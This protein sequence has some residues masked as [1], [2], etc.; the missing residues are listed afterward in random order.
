MDQDS[1]ISVWE[2]Y[3]AKTCPGKESEKSN[4]QKHTAKYSYAPNIGPAT[5][6]SAY[7]WPTMDKRRVLL[8]R[9]VAQTNT[10]NVLRAP[11]KCRKTRKAKTER[12]NTNWGERVPDV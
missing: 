2:P 3:N 1:V 6:T 11:P 10:F 9:G 7:V 12:S 4:D 8:I 5:C